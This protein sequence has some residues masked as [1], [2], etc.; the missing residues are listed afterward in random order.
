MP[1]TEYDVSY[2]AVLNAGFTY[3]SSSGTA[4]QGTPFL[5]VG[6]TILAATRA[7]KDAAGW[8][9]LD[10]QSNASAVNCRSAIVRPLNTAFTL[11]AS[12]Y[13]YGGVR[14]K[15]LNVTR[16]PLVGIVT[17]VL[18]ATLVGQVNFLQD[19]DV[20]GG[21]VN[22]REYWFEWAMDL[23]NK[24]VLR[25]LDGVALPNLTLTDN[26]VNQLIAGTI[27]MV[28]GQAFAA[29]M[30]GWPTNAWKD[31]FMGYRAA[32]EVHEFLGPRLIV[33]AAVKAITAP[34]AASSGTMVA[35]LNTPV[36]TA[37]SFLTPFI[38][39]DVAASSADIMLEVPTIVGTIEGVVIRSVAKRQDATISK[40]EAYLTDDVG[41][42]DKTI[43]TLDGTMTA[44]KLG[45]YK[46]APSGQAWT[47]AK[48]ES[49]TLKIKPT[50]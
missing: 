22:G 20:P 44:Y 46:N 12:S 41:S 48:L 45:V 29:N 26:T 39:S 23:A 37:A 8:L 17:T 24:R 13:I 47:K 31:I 32:G 42:T 6:D 10:R 43:S 27:A 49:A 38:T 15:S 33:P 7:V 50:N 40:I 5:I 34:W 35:A 30:V 36:T 18:P 3:T 21:L 9:T 19:S 2:D 16:I 25:R 14:V 1:I 4:V 11:T 28:Y